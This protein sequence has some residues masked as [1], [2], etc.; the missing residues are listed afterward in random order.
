MRATSSPKKRGEKGERGERGD[1]GENKGIGNLGGNRKRI[2]RLCADTQFILDYKEPKL[3]TV[4]VT[5]RGKIV[6]RRLTG[7]CAYHQR[8]V[9]ET[10]K[11][12]RIL[13][14]LP[15]TNSQK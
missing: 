13:A 12:S 7:N 4:F 5:D 10:I 2:C 15:F 14:F 3:L 6:P 1:R 9:Q 11:R 8:R